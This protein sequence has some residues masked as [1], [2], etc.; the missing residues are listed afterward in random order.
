MI[1]FFSAVHSAEPQ[2]EDTNWTEEQA[3]L[4][5]SQFGDEPLRSGILVVSIDEDSGVKECIRHSSPL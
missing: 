3:P 2:F 5:F 4:A 1:R